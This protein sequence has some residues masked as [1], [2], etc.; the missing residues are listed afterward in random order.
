MMQLIRKVLHKLRG[1]PTASSAGHADDDYSRRVAKELESYNETTN[2]HDLPPIFHYWSNKY[3]VPKLAPFG[4]TDPEQF[5]FLYAQKF[6]AHFPEQAI[7]MVS[8]GSGNCDMEARMAQRLVEKGITTFTIE[9]LDIN[10]NM[11]ERGREV[12][13]TSG[14]AQHIVPITGDFNYW[15]PKGTYDLVLANQCLHHVVELENLFAAIK[16]CLNPEGYFLVS[17]MIGRNGHLRWPEALKVVNEIWPELPDNYRYNYELSRHEPEF[18]NHD[19]SI[20]AFEGIR[21][22]DILPLLIDNFKFEFFLP[23]ANVVYSFIDRAM[24]HNFDVNGEWDKD[25]VDRVHARDEEGM[26]SGEL[27]PTQM[28]AVLRTVDIETQLLHPKLT[29]EF[30]MRNP[31]L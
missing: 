5:F 1:V 21:A 29:P 6:H 10:T 23:F 19:C 28:L 31:D 4:I 8:I 30:C 20:D 3:L 15:Q 12:A 27:K 25:F 11:L 26:L 14:V 22:Q 7:R 9:C 24:G 18:I 16:T 13:A 2:I 17:D